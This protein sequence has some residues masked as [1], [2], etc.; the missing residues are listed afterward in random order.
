MSPI[1]H[2]EDSL[3]AMPPMLNRAHPWRKI[4][5]IIRRKDYETTTTIFADLFILAKQQVL[6][7]GLF[8]DECGEILEMA[9]AYQLSTQIPVYWP[10]LSSAFTSYFIFADKRSSPKN[11][12]ELTQFPEQ[13]A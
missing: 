11:M 1:A 3:R 13:S 9:R 2:T 6:S 4:S 7:L 5:P 10:F 12:F 8:G